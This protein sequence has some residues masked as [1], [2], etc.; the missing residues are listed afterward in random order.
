MKLTKGVGVFII[1]DGQLLLLKRL[2]EPFKD[3]WEVP[4]GKVDNLEKLTD[5]VIRE[6][7]EETG[8]LVSPEEKIGVNINQENKFE[9]HMFKAKIVSGELINNEPDK[10]SDL[11]F[12]PLNNLPIPLGSTTQKGLEI[13]L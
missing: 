6:V 5:T 7:Q 12:F 10:H 4:A 13:L 9:S 8:L 11:K 1:K 3:Y 2:K